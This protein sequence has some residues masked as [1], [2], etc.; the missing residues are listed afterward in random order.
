[1][2]LGPQIPF[3]QMD[4]FTDRPFHGS[5]TTAFLPVEPLDPWA[6]KLITREMKLSG[7][8]RHTIEPRG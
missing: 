4:A 2:A 5:P 3:Y 1:M 6:M 7:H 8:L